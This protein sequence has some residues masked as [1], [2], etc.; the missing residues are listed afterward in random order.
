MRAVTYIVILLF[1]GLHTKHIAGEFFL[2]KK[3]IT[4]VGV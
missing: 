4:E 3:L 2:N 1:L